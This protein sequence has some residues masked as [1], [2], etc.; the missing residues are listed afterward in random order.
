MAVITSSSNKIASG[1]LGVTIS[2]IASLSSNRTIDVLS[3]GSIKYD[4]DVPESGYDVKSLYVRYGDC[5]ISFRDTMDDGSSLYDLVLTAT[6][7]PFKIELSLDANSGSTYSFLFYAYRNDVKLDEISRVTEI[8]MKPLISDG[9]SVADYFDGGLDVDPAAYLK[10]AYISNEENTKVVASGRFIRDILKSFNNFSGFVLES[11]S[12]E[13]IESFSN[14]VGY[15]L[16]G[17]PFPPSGDTLVVPSQVAVSA[18]TVL[19]NFAGEE[20]AIF[21]S[22]FNH[23]FYVQRTSNASAVNV[24][25]SEI[26]SISVDRSEFEYYTVNV[27]SSGGTAY[28]STSLLN[29]SSE[30]YNIGAPKRFSFTSLV[31]CGLYGQWRTNVQPDPPVGNYYSN[32]FFLGS[33]GQGTKVDTNVSVDCYAK[34]IGAEIIERIDITVFGFDAIKPWNTLRIDSASGVLP[35]NLASRYSG[36]IFR[37]SALDYSFEDDKIKI[38]AYRIE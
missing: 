8:R 14:G 23:N 6:T 5:T 25:Y 37:P 28:D 11:D 10:D 7:T 2:G 36:S 15:N 34:G 32:V 21:G 30:T 4:F 19:F 16:V 38:R 18:L 1:V 33:D 26:E 24:S 22:S 17:D 3:V 29:S 31:S 13:D 9:K 20:G 27:V 12:H 35:P